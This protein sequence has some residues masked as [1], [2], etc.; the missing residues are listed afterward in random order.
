MRLSTA[1]TRVI[2][3]VE[4]SRACRFVII[5]S[6]SIDYIVPFAEALSTEP[7][8]YKKSPYLARGS[9]RTI[10]IAASGNWKKL[11]PM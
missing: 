5:E 7:V 2:S 1:M 9:V 8:K 11:T 6:T 3:G 4:L 10:I